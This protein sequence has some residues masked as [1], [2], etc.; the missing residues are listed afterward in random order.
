MEPRTDQ[1]TGRRRILV[2]D[3]DAPIQRLLDV[4]LRSAGFEVQA[5]ATATEGLA[6]VATARPDLIVAETRFPTGPDGFDF[7][8]QVK[9]AKPS[10][11]GELGVAFIFRAE[12]TMDS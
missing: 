4:N 12:Q 6:V 9:Q 5:V 3:G 10:A 1:Q 2:V 7:C 8:R 11:A